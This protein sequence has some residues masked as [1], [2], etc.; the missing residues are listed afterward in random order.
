MSEITLEELKQRLNYDPDTGIFTWKTAFSNRI[1]V[2]QEAGHMKNNGYR[3]VNFRG[4]N[5]L[6]HRLA[7]FY[8]YGKMPEKD[9]DHINRNRMD[10]RIT[11]LREASHKENN[12]N[13]IGKGYTFFKRDG[14]WK[15]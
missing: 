15:A 7:W 9:L 8:Y 10:N 11:N 2:G 14:T 6:T 3:S 12:Y 4:K 1:K 5:Y 13:R